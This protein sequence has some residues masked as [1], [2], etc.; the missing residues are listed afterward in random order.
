MIIYT[1]IGRQSDAAVLVDC[2]DPLLKGNAGVVTATLFC[3][4]KDHPEFLQEGQFQTM[5]QRNVEES[6]DFLSHFIEACSTA[7]GDEMVDEHYFHI[8]YVKGVI[9]MCIGDD[10]N[11]SDQKVNFAFLEHISKE[12]TRL[13]NPRRIRNANAYGMEKT[14]RP[15]MS[16]AMHHYNINHDKMAQEPKIRELESQ[17]S[18]LKQV[19]G[20][21]MNL[22]LE[23]GEN[24]DRMMERSEALEA[25]AQ[26]FRKK[27]KV[28]LKTMRLKYYKTVL[29]YAGLVGLV[30][31]VIVCTVLTRVCGID[32]YYC[33][34]H[35]D[36]DN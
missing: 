2:C 6:V 20:R 22:L 25:D 3:H 16:Q 7:L 17:L 23:R 29:I 19:L 4:L 36:H 31:A 15:N 21:N 11:R 18:D 28:M 8:Y 30:V 12:F 1:A 5:I 26:V 13:H 32:L 35:G 24:L 27:S 10:S 33:R 34:G 14:F 9:Y